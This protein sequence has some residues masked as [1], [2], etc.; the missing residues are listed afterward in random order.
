MGNEKRRTKFG[1]WANRKFG[2]SVIGRLAA[3]EFV[4]NGFSLKTRKDENFVTKVSFSGLNLLVE[5]ELFGVMVSW[6]ASSG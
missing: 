1:R 2:K 4:P 6:F 5:F 3:F